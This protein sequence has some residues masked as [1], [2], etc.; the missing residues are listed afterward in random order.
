MPVVGAGVSL[1][2]ALANGTSV[3]AEYK[4]PLSQTQGS[5]SIGLAQ[6]DSVVRNFGLVNDFSLG[7]GLA[8]PLGYH[9]SGGHG[10]AAARENYP[11][12]SESWGGQWRVTGIV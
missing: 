7:V 11:L 5:G 3:L 10:P 9:A 12:R 1:L 6:I 4:G 2:A 8:N